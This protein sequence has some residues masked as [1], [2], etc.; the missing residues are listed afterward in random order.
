MVNENQLMILKIINLSEAKTNIDTVNTQFSKVRHL[1]D[2]VI[3]AMESAGALD[4]ETS[5]EYKKIDADIFHVTKFIESLGSDVRSKRRSVERDM[6]NI[7][8]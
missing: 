3:R 4:K 1:L 8:E 2:E 5:N 7:L 6:Y